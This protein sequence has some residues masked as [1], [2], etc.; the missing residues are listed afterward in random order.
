MNYKLIIVIIIIYM[1]KNKKLGKLLV[2]PYESFSNFVNLPSSV[3]NKLTKIKNHNSQFFFEIKSSHTSVYVGVK[4]FNEQLEGCIEVPSWISQNI[5]ESH[6]LVT[7]I[8]NVSKGR[9][10]KIEPQEEEF[11]NIP[12]SD[13]ILE[14]ELA[15]YCLLE[16][17]QTIPIKIFDETYHFKII[18]MK[19][20][21]EEENENECNLIDIVD[22]DL[23]VDFHNKFY[24]EEEKIKEDYIKYDETEKD[25]MNETE[26][27]TKE[28]KMN[29]KEDIDKTG[30]ILGGLTI[31]MKDV[32][33]ARLKF[34]EKK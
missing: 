24:K 13:A 29:E 15:K 27:Y 26:D 31:D 12:E 21:S 34:F 6:V 28:E 19:Y 20:D 16:L 32:R 23:N 9:F 33:L 2:L 17:N 4:D 30:N 1:L 18:E 3:L 10:V 11:F 14:I 22:V 5:G 25:K 8:K 7:L